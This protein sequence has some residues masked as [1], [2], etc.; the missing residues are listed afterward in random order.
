MDAMAIARDMTAGEAKDAV[1]AWVTGADH[2]RFDELADG[3]VLCQVTH[4]NLKQ[5]IIEL[6]FDLH[7]TVRATKNNLYTYNGTNRE[8]MELQLFEGDRLVSRLA[9]AER[10]PVGGAAAPVPA[11]LRPPSPRKTA[12]G[13]AS[14]CF[15]PGFFGAEGRGLPCVGPRRARGA[16]AE[17]SESVARA[18]ALHAAHPCLAP[19]SQ[20]RSLA[21][22]TTTR[23]WASTG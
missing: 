11:L 9:A 7:S 2:R 21:C 12:S 17:R 20:R 3:T 16:S 19:R 8:F 15:G 1:R 6:R 14:S 22:L 10:I 4:S 13:L 18:R 5:N 23:C